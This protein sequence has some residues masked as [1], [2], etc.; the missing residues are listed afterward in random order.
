M[1]SIILF[2][3]LC[4]QSIMLFGTDIIGCVTD[5]EGKKIPYVNVVAINV[6]DS[7]FVAG[8]VTSTDGMFALDLRK[9]KYILKFSCI[10]LKTIY[11][12]I[13][14]VKNADIGFVEMEDDALVLNEVVVKGSRPTITR[15]ATG[16]VVTLE[17]SKQLQNKSLDRILNASPGVYID[18]LGEISI[19]G[20]S[21]VTVVIN[22]KTMYLTGDQLVSYMNSIQGSDLKSIEIISNPT[23][24]YDA[25][26]AGGV[27]RIN[28]RK[29]KEQGLSGYVSSG[30]IYCRK[31]RFDEAL[32]LTYT[33]G[34]VTF[35]GNYTFY[36]EK[37]SNCRDATEWLASG[38]KYV[39]SEYHMQTVNNNTYRVGGDWQISDKHFLGFEYN[40]QTKSER[41]SGLTEVLSYI[42]DNYEGRVATDNPIINKPYNNL[43][44]LN[45][46]LKIDTLGQQL[47]MVADYS[48]VN[49]SHQNT[50]GYYNKY[51]DVQDA[52]LNT[53]NRRQ[54]LSE[55]IDIYS[56]QIDYENRFHTKNW[57]FSAG[58]KFSRVETDYQTNFFNWQNEGNEPMEDMKYKDHFNY[59]EERYAVYINAAYSNKKL[60]TNA[61][62]RGEYTKTEG[63][64]HISGE[65]NKDDYIKLFPS[66]FLYYKA[67]EKH[68]LM[69]YYGM[70]IRRPDY[71]VVNP[72]TF[73]STEVSLRT[74]NPNLK[75]DISNVIEL[76]Y[77]LRNKYYFSLRASLTDK[78]MKSYLYMENGKTVYTYGNWDSMNYYYFNAYIPFD[79]NI[80]SSSFLLNAGM[81]ETKAG[82]RDKQT[83]N[84]ELEWQNYF[85]I[86]DNLGCEARFVYSP[87]FKMV[88]EEFR[89]HYA[90]LN[91]NLDYSLLKDKAMINV[92]VD[93]IFN[94]SGKRHV[95]SHYDDVNSDVTLVPAFSGRT[96]RISLKLNFNAGGKVKRRGKEKSN[97]DEMERL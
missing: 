10:S 2:F 60:D 76:T 14:L 70:R 41:S 11:K 68:G 73:Y 77:V 22:D 88:Y 59:D 55:N 49:N 35:Y 17:N 83:F 66:A 56:V 38:E 89:R 26:G 40:G 45:Y 33:I 6:K 13:D 23:S 32:G 62:L 80:W 37:N 90:K 28:T 93:D 12:D 63:V 8:T 7:T 46:I 42:N 57:K 29:R 72:F 84:M 95:L 75:P 92:G 51:Y 9:N 64:S 86:M 19:N 67:N 18:R 87:P 1:K 69:A 4:I 25:E 44:N 21:G 74:G 20:R 54:Y 36:R 5:K 43:Y 39:T 79:W 94:S 61:G 31:P 24:S 91:I 3:L 27:I 15:K 96:Y 97:S 65:V 34:N 50:Y 47:K 85:R 81:L 78:A 30:L 58:T 82:G 48:D 16:F 52:F 53:Q 71:E